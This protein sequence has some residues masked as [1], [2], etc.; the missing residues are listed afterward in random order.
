MGD[1]SSDLNFVPPTFALHAYPDDDLTPL[2]VGYGMT[3]PDGSALAVGWH[4]GS[5]AAV[6]SCGSA[7]GAAFIYDAEVVWSVDPGSPPQ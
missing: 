7:D 4:D 3:L 5:A 2:V 1:F 6:A